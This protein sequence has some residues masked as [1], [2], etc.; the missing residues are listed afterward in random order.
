MAQQAGGAGVYH[1]D[2]VGRGCHGCHGCLAFAPGVFDL[3]FLI[4]FVLCSSHFQD[5][6]NS[7]DLS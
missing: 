7:L 5:F 1:S 2:E 6:F 3:D 4:F